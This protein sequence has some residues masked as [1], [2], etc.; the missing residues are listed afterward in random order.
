[1][2]Q[3]WRNRELPDA[4][5]ASDPVARPHEQHCFLRFTDMAHR[6]GDQGLRSPVRRFEANRAEPAARYDRQEVIGPTRLS[7]FPS[8]QHPIA[9]ARKDKTGAFEDLPESA[10]G[11]LWVEISHSVEPD[12]ARNEP[13]ASHLASAAH[14]RGIE[15]RCMSR[16]S[17]TVVRIAAESCP[18][19]TAEFQDL[20]Q[21]H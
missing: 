8:K 12:Q 18:P 7:D 21:H 15:V 13:V 4:E 5:C 14:T 19:V 3:I 16:V 9:A 20:D 11:E 10:T 1:M 2:A 6:D 17:V